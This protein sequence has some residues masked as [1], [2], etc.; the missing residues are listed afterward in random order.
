M[1]GG[2]FEGVGRVNMGNVDR[3]P[4]YVALGHTGAGKNRGDFWGGGTPGLDS[5]PMGVG[6]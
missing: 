5:W 6:G 3:V 1:V 4:C 2:G